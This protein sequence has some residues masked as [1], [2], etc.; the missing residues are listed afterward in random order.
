MIT[1]VALLMNSLL[2]FTEIYAIIYDQSDSRNFN[3]FLLGV[4]IIIHL[5]AFRH[6]G[7]DIRFREETLIYALY[8]V[9]DEKA[10]RYVAENEWQFMKFGEG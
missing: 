6:A 9:H 7:K 1:N 3:I 2:M 4:M 5:I 10:E 8:L